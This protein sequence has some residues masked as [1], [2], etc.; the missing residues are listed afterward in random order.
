MADVDARRISES[1]AD[2]ELRDL[3]KGDGS[4]S[5]KLSMWKQMK[6]E[7]RHRLVVHKLAYISMEGFL[8]RQCGV[9]GV[10]ECNGAGHSSQMSQILARRV[11]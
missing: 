2:K 7:V 10:V 3:Q 11:R 8:M 1:N 9:E 5:D 6:A 4:G